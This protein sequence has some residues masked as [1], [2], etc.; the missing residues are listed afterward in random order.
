V[1]PASTLQ[2]RLDANVELVMIIS[3]QVG[4]TGQALA[5]NAQQLGATGQQ[6]QS[7]PARPWLAVELCIGPG[8]AQKVLRRSVTRFSCDHGQQ[9]P[10]RLD[11][12]PAA[13]TSLGMGGGYR[14][15]LPIG[16]SYGDIVGEVLHPFSHANKSVPGRT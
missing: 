14:I 3:V 2:A 11:Q 10:V 1:E 12:V 9:V 4:A 5:A 6:G 13:L 7:L 8:P 15:G 16:K